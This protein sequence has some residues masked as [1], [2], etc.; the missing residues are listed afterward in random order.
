MSAAVDVP[1]R[2]PPRAL[3][4]RLRLPRGGRIAAV[5]VGGRAWSRFDRATGTIDLSGLTGHLDVVAR[6]SRA[7]ATN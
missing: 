2:T 3:S 7:R 5:T 1:E 6:L 4:L